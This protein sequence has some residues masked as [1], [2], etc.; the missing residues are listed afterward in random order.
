[1]ILQIQ[2]CCE[3]LNLQE[4]YSQIYFVAPNWNPSIE[5]QAIARCH[6]YGQSKQVQ[7]FRFYMEESMDK[8]ILFIQNSKRYVINDAFKYDDID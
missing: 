1:L 4:N 2:T 6:R 8:Y 7:V 5:E 3:G